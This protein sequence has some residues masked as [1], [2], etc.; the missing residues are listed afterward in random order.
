MA[1]FHLP[2]G[3]PGTLSWLSQQTG[4]PSYNLAMS[5]AGQ[6]GHFGNQGR[7]YMA[8]MMHRRM[9]QMALAAMNQPT[10]Q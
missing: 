5:A 8:Q 3:T 9:R 2:A 10:Q 1:E 4:I 6:P 7:Y